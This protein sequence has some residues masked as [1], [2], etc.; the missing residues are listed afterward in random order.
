MKQKKYIFLAVL[1]VFLLSG[2]GRKSEF[3]YK[4]L[5][6][7][8]L[9]ILKYMGKDTVVTVPSEIDGKT[10]SA[11]C[12]SFKDNRNVREVILP[13]TL[14]NIE[15]GTFQNA[16]NLLKVSGGENVQ[17][18]EWRAFENCFNLQRVSQFPNLIEIGYLAFYKC[19]DL[20]ELKLEEKLEI[21]GDDAFFDVQQLEEVILPE[22]VKKI[23]DGA[24]DSIPRVKAKVESVVTAEDIVIKCPS[25]GEE[26]WVPKEVTYI[27]NFYHVD[28]EKKAKKVYVPDTVEEILDM[29]EYFEDEVTLYLPSSVEYIGE[30]EDETKQF[31][32]NVSFVVEKGSYAESYAKKYKIPYEVVED[33]QE[34]YDST[35]S[36]Y[37]SLKESEE[38]NTEAGVEESSEE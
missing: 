3:T 30:T 15:A 37:E 35:L 25:E 4:E 21:I 22:S 10:V 17:T 19:K 20:E 18:I 28:S 11:M 12:A 1:I 8:T 38:K 16:Y 2:C 14:V 9:C 33:V 27:R 32:D 24:L 13:D 7:G 36:A 6:N 23:G 29:G 26:V 5:E 34:I 31:A